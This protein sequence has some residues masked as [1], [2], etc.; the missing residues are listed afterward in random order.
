[1]TFLSAVANVFDKLAEE[2]ESKPVVA[3][4]AATPVEVKADPTKI[5]EETVRKVAG[6]DLP[7]ETVRKVAEDANLLDL[8]SKVAAEKDRPTPMGG[9]SEIKTAQSESKKE[10]LDSAFDSWGSSIVRNG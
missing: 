3:E 4:K 6:K 2:A 7:L 10:R 1:M 8:L 9:P 5:A